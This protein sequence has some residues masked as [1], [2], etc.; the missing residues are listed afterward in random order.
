ME[1]KQ[2]KIERIIFNNAENGYT[3]AL[4]ETEDEQFTITG[5][6]H[7]PNPGVQY[8]LTG[9]FRTH[10]KYG[11]QF[12]VSS[13]EEVVPDDSEG[14][15]AFLASGAIRGIGPKLAGLIVDRFGDETL[16]VI[17]NEPE[18]LLKVK[19]IGPKSLEVII[20]SYRSTREFTRV[21]FELRELGIE[22]AQ[23]VRIYKLYG[24]E[25]LQVVRD[26]PY[27][28][29]E[30]IYGISF[31]RA[32]AIAMKIGFEPDSEFRIQSG[33]G[34]VLQEWAV[35]GSTFMPKSLLVEK[36][37][38]LLDVTGDLVEDNLLAMTFQGRIQAD[39][40]NEVP[41]VY[42]YGYYLAEQRVA[43]HLRQLQ[44]AFIPAP[45]AEIDHL[46]ADAEA[47]SYGIRL[48][49]EQRKA[50]RTALQNNIC[51]ITGGPGTGKTTIINTLVRILGR[52]D[53]TVALAAPTGRAAKRI[54]ETSGVP[55]QTIHRLLE[56]VFSEDEQEMEFGRNEENPLEENVVIIDEASMV[57]LMLM[58][59]LL[60][61]LKP[62][63][64]LIIVGD[65]DQLPSVGAGNV[66][67]DMIRS[68]YIPTVRL[69]EIFRQA[70]ESLIVVN[71]HRINSGEYPTANARDRDFFIMRKP[72]E[73]SILQT[74]TELFGGR[75]ERYYDFIHSGYD[76]QVLTP[77]KKG[78]LGTVNLNKVLQEVLNPPGLDP[79]GRQ[80]REKHAGGRVFREG[81]K[82]MQIRNNYG[83]EWK[84]FSAGPEESGGPG[85]RGIPLGVAVTS[86]FQSG[87]GVFNGDMGVIERIDNEYDR[88]SVRF[89][90][91]VAIYESDELAELEL[92]YAVTVHKSQGSEFPAIIM[93]MTWF[94][95]MLMTRNLLYTGVTRGKQLVVIVGSEERLRNMVDNNRSDE[96]FTGLE[97]RLREIDYGIDLL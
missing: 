74:I 7:E 49:D 28:L 23:A 67:R 51:I 42:L 15:R 53:Q 24:A 27:S 94:P 45:A 63:T 34:Y 58:D 87:Q 35:N 57:D 78:L 82:V 19:G 93:P 88:I 26:N 44:E 33:I 96:R 90:D 62:G 17:E 76:I 41:V 4:F 9:E 46:I 97:H 60:T 54:T 37:I 64:R 55:A 52:L 30:D 18:R 13:Y 2:G 25:S 40:V 95:P 73:E 1:S 89:D 3:V 36:T 47:A 80:K 59:G 91:R 16:E 56:Y 77:T 65:A 20:E 86:E 5:S 50:I 6:F 72:D 32:D 61:A 81:D 8:R 84:R 11:E 12:A 66:L 21:S 68:E 92:A 22:M 39:V 31:R 29:V 75:L 79:Q 43:F 70:E 83:M 69:R 85:R 10:R 71:A 48:A 38:Q 14:I